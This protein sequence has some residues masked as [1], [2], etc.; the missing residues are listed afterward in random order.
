MWDFIVQSQPWLMGP[1]NLSGSPVHSKKQEVG[2]SASFSF[3][4]HFFTAAAQVHHSLF[5]LR[6]KPEKKLITLTF[7]SDF[8]SLFLSFFLSQFFVHLSSW[9]LCLSIVRN[10]FW[11]H[12]LP[13]L[14][15]RRLI[16][17][18]PVFSLGVSVVM[19]AFLRESK[20]VR[21]RQGDRWWQWL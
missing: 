21:A 20:D 19:L 4:F 18:L 17:R 5:P 2:T 10:H 3:H 14:Q 1:F 15:W 7:L 12:L 11:S 8:Q 6:R 9:W 13:A 16:L